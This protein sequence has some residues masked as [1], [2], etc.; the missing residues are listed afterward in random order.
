MND[1]TIFKTICR[2]IVFHWVIMIGSMAG[3]AFIQNVLN[4]LKYQFQILCLT[5]SSYMHLYP[6]GDTIDPPRD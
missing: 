6:K 3:L 4:Y 1:I 2:H 5:K